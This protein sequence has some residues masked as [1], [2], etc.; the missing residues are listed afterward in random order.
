MRKRSKQYLAKIEK[1]SSQDVQSPKEA[2]KLIK[3]I[4]NP[5]FDETVEVHYNL[6]IDPRHADQQLRGTLQLPKGSG[7]KVRILAVVKDENVEKAKKAGAD[8]AG[9]D[10]VIEKI[11]KGWLDF[12]LVIAEPSVMSKVGKVGKILGTKGLM[13]SPKS[14]TVTPGFEK[15]IKEFKSGKVEYRNDKYGII[16]V[17]I[18]KVSFSEEDLTENFISLYDKISKE[19]PNKSKGV[20]LKSISVC[21]T[22]SPSVS[23]ETQSI[24]WKE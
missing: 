5:N 11:Q 16:H 9:C 17:G 21:T 20:Y 22:M 1:V 12:D 18:G 23:I 4:S 10:E 15:A 13:P 6:G 8:E 3:A 2:M 19:K 7:K 14:G 24:K